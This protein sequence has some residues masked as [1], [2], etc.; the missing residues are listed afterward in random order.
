MKW[1]FVM[2]V[3]VFSVYGDY[4][5]EYT[6]ADGKS[7]I[8]YKDKEH[9]KLLPV[10]DVC[11]GG[12]IYKIKKKIYSVAYSGGYLVTVDLLKAKNF[13]GSMGISVT[14][15]D[16]EDVAGAYDDYTITKTSKTKRIAGIKAYKWI[17]SD[18]QT[19]EKE[20]IW[21]SSDKRLLQVTQGASTLF[22]ALSGDNVNYFLIDG[23]VVVQGSDFTLSDFKETTF[24]KSTFKLPNKRSK[25]LKMC[26]KRSQEM[27]LKDEDSYI[28][29]Q[30][31]EIDTKP[32]KTQDI[33]QKVPNNENTKDDLSAE[34]IQKAADMLKSFF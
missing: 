34:D 29:E 22:S 2:I 28:D 33:K 9:I 15:A 14:A 18:P 10:E 12:E 21:V 1:L 19:K 17:L 16:S 13:M 11:Q 30:N 3:S 23:W 24:P 20:V 8:Y 4:L 25:T 27:E 5:L 26:A 6:G 32:S 31:S 7:R